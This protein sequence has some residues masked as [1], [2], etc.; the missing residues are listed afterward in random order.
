MSFLRYKTY[1]FIDKDPVI[2]ELRT[3]LTRRKMTILELHERS[4][5][6]KGTIRKWFYGD[7]KRPTHATVK[8]VAIALGFQYKL[9]RR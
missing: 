6:S 9:V 2:D 5:V 8:A 7:T 4:G 1:N 3:Q